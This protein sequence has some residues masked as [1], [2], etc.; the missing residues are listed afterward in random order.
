[1]SDSVRENSSLF[2]SGSGSLMG[3]EMFHFPMIDCC[4]SLNLTASSYCCFGVGFQK[5]S[6]TAE[7]PV[8]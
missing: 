2:G 3:V 8:E 6:L 5:R 4:C 1:M 7:V